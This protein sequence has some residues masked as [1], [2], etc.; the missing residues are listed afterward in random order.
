VSTLK[1]IRELTAKKQTEQAVKEIAAEIIASPLPERLGEDRSKDGR[2]II[3]ADSKG[4]VILFSCGHRVGEKHFTTKSCP[5]C[6]A[7]NKKAHAI[8]KTANK[9]TLEERRTPSG[10]LP[11]G[12]IF[13]M[14]YHADREIW[15]GELSLPDGH[16]FH[17]ECSAILD[18]P[19]KLDEK[20]R[21]ALTTIE[22]VVK[23]ERPG[24]L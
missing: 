1:R 5:T 8:K 24:K 16:L 4:I 9:P 13:R 6:R 20:Y 7:A 11:D 14:T 22:E 21:A 10:R 18:L 17:A 19:K 23:K 3:P 15:D 2:K 12:A